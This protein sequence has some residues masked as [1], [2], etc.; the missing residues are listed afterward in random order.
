MNSYTLIYI[1]CIVVR[2]GGIRG[3]TYRR[4]KGDS[5]EFVISTFEKNIGTGRK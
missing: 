4:E 1:C 3:W 2:W 5:E